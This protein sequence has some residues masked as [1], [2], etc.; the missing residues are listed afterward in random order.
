M[1]YASNT[2]PTIGRRRPVITRREAEVLKLVAQGS[3]ARAI[4][5]RLGISP[6]TVD[7]HKEALKLKCA[8]GDFPLVAVRLGLVRVEVTG[9]LREAYPDL[10]D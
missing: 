1:P 9:E 4:A 8:A 2:L 10:C 5:G 6:K 7:S 3:Q